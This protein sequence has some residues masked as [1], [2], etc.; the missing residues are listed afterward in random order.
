MDDSVTMEYSTTRIAGSDDSITAMPDKPLFDIE[1]TRKELKDSISSKE[2]K[3]AAEFEKVV[4]CFCNIMLVNLNAC[5]DEKHNGRVA[6]LVLACCLIDTFAG[7]YAGS[8]FDDNKVGE[9]WKLFVENYLQNYLGSSPNDQ[10]LYTGLRC[11][12][13]HNFSEGV[14]DGSRLV[15]AI[16]LIG[17]EAPEGYRFESAGKFTIYVSKFV[18]D[19]V[20]AITSY[21]KDVFAGKT[22]TIEHSLDENLKKHF[23]DFGILEIKPADSSAISPKTM[24]D[25]GKDTSAGITSGKVSI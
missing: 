20:E 25:A 14:K 21:L 12:L 19:V 9:N 24:T 18:R 13:L 4:D 5:L 7:F 2:L 1:A 23:M 16:E 15:G 3:Y 8:R 22:V 11:K 6:A 10:I 17:G